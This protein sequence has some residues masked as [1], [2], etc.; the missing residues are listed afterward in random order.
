MRPSAV[1]LLVL[2][3]LYTTLAFEECS[4]L[5][6]QSSGPSCDNPECQKHQCQRHKF[7]YPKVSTQECYP[8]PRSNFWQHWCCLIG[9]P[10]L[11]MPLLDCLCLPSDAQK[12]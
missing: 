10:F 5:E 12:L 1:V 3:T 4:A 11:V 8:H 7:V 6:P 2:L 9:T